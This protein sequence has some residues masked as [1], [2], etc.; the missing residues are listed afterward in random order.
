MKTRAVRL[1]GKEDLRL[2]EF[3]LP[4][5]E[6]D[7]ILAEVVSDS[8]CMSSYKAAKQGVEHKRVPKDLATNPTII[9]HEFCGRILEVGAK[10]RS[11]FKEGSKFAIQPALNYRGSLAAPGYSYRAIGGDATYVII[12]N[13]VMECGCLLEYRGRGFFPASLSEP[14]SCIIGAFRASYHTRPGDYTHQM[15]IREAGSM[16]LLAAAGPMG[17]GFID[18]ALHGPR[19]PSLL[20]V[21]DIDEARLER[22]ASLFSA[23]EAEGRGVKLRFVDTRALAGV[24]KH[25]MSLSEGRGYDD[26][27]V[28]APVKQVVES[29]DRILGRDG[30]LNFFA[31]PT[32]AAFRAE[33]NF[34]NVHYAASHLVGTSGGNTEDM[35]EALELMAAGRI[36][37]SF[38]ITHVG[39]L[40]AVRDTTLHLPEIPGGKKLI[41]THLELELAALDDFEARGRGDPL[42]RELAAITARHGGLWSLEAEE[43]LLSKARKAG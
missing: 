33:V 1:Y 34:Y 26:V 39:G 38:M 30:C 8:L 9:G 14:M 19:Q 12:P 11:R 41:Y 42:F 2:E 4:P 28:L 16:A 7:E 27:F 3:E 20:V 32:D 40:N 29:G 36:N 17:L 13:E 23:K 18:Y 43:C 22:A 15:G 24:E 5:L 6:E 10:W 25:L 21:T 31:G 37:P 35:V